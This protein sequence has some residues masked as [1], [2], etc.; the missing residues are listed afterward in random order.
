[1]YHG[2]D[3]V[4]LALTK[5]FYILYFLWILDGKCQPLQYFCQTL[6]ISYFIDREKKLLFWRKLAMHHNNT[7]LLSF[8][9]VQNRFYAIGSLYDST[10]LSDSVGQIKSAVWAKFTE[11]V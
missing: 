3:Y 1:M 5:F 4:S 11:S 2:G 10:T 9:A 6:P 7:V 8:T